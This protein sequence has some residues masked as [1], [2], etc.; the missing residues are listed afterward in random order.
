VGIGYGEA[1]LEA[2]AHGWIDGKM[3]HIN[4]N[5]FMQRFTPHR[6]N[7]L[8]SQSNRERAEYLISQG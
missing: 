4:K 2:V 5:E 8:W 7:S 6:S 1:V 3:K